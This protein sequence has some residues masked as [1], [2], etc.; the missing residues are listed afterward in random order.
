MNEADGTVFFA[1]GEPDQDIQYLIEYA[2]EHNHPFWLID[3]E[4]STPLQAAFQINI[5]LTRYVIKTL[6][7]TG[8]LNDSL[9]YENVYQC[10]NSTMMLGREEIPDQ[11][12]YEREGKPLPKTVDEAVRH[13]ID[14]MDLKDKVT[15][16]NMTAGEVE[17]LNVSLGNAI[18][19]KFGLWD[20]NPELFWS[21]SKDAGKEVKHAD[22]ASAIIIARL[23]LELEKSH[24]LRSV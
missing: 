2:T 11:W 1:N 5:W 19:N 13:L 10:M 21:C 17:G 16:A 15:I 4:Q 3:F 22:E 23:A 8:T 7:I 12:Q 20:G 9:V 6:H 18:R 24:K 14:E